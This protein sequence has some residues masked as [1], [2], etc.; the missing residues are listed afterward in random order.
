[1]EHKDFDSGHNIHSFWFLPSK[2]FFL[3]GKLRLLHGAVQQWLPSPQM[4]AQHYSQESKSTDGSRQFDEKLLEHLVCPLSKKDLRY[5]KQ[6]NELV[7]DEIGVAYPI[8]NGI[9]N[10][11]PQDARMLKKDSSPPE[12]QA[13]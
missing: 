1:M 10:L 4:N 8:V 2:G 12:K 3:T 9:P 6:R 5:D 11:V 7:C 13:S